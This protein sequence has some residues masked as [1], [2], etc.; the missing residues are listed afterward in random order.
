MRFFSVRNWSLA[1]LLILLTVSQAT[2]QQNQNQNQRR[3]RPALPADV[4]VHRDVEYARVGDKS[5]LLDIYV[6]EKVAA[7][8]PLVVWIHGGGWRN[9][10]KNQTRAV[11][12]IKHGFAVASIGYRL[13]GEAI[14]P[15][16]I[17]DCKA[18]I[19]WLRANADEYGL[20]ANHFGVWGS[21]A[22]GHLVALLGTSGGAQ[23][24][25][26]VGNHKEV[27]SNVQAVCDFYGPTDFLQMDKHAIEGSR[28]IHDSPDSPE[29]RLI[30]APIQENPDKVARANP[31]TFVS[32]DDPPFLIY[33]GD[34]DPAV[35]FHQSQLLNEALQKAGVEVT[36]RPLEGAGHGGP[37]FGTPEVE[38]EIAEFFTRHLKK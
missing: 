26:I 37:Q 35:P 31:I 7:P 9:G 36:F 17:A 28:L 38:A 10:S 16:Q 12:M 2:A 32:A 11:G 15:A 22:G 14:F 1:A 29:S 13:S 27:S 6:P 3:R 24:F 20:D 33:H 5:L 21:S 23:E 4:T 18:A 8:R 30:G 25:E 19:R 34:K